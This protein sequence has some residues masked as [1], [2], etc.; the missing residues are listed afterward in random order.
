[1]VSHYPSRNFTRVG[2]NAGLCISNDCHTFTGESE[3]ISL[4]GLRLKTGVPL[5]VETPLQI[6]VYPEAKKPFSF[7][8]EIIW[9]DESSYGIEIINMPLN[10]F[11]TIREIVFS[12][13]EFPESVVNEVFGVVKCLGYS[14]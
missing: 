6:M 1:M 5:P 9:S 11:T 14:R 3:N 8:G 7:I 2:F 13:S 10:S 4:K 12:R